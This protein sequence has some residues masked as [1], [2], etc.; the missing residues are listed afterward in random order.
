MRTA[1]WAGVIVCGAV[2][3]VCSQVRMVVIARVVAHLGVG[4]GL[5]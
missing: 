1:M 5:H 4:A 2:G 3:M